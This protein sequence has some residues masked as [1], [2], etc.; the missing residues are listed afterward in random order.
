MSGQS[1]LLRELTKRCRMVRHLLQIAPAVSADLGPRTLVI[2][3]SST[4]TSGCRYRAI[5]RAE[6]WRALAEPL[7]LFACFRPCFSPRGVPVT[8]G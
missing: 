4:V 1:T 6:R 8:Q 7:G 2:R 5:Q 3:P